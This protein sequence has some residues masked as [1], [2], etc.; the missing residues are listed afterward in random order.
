M[1]INKL[2]LENVFSYYGNVKFDFSNS[3]SLNVIIGENGFGKTSLINSIKIALHG[4]TK[5]VLRIGD[6]SLTKQ[7]YIMGSN[8][9]SG[10]INRVAKEQG[11]KESS[12]SIN[13][14][15]EKLNIHTIKRCFKIT[16]TSYSEYLTVTKE[17]TGT[18]LIDDEAQDYINS[19]IIN[20]SLAK[21]FL[22]DGER[23][24]DIANFS[25]EEFAK[26]LENVFEEIGIFEQLIE[27]MKLLK[28][29]YQTESI[30][31]KSLQNLFIEKNNLIDL[32]NKEIEN[33]IEN[34]KSKK[35][36]LREFK[37]TGTELKNKIEKLKSENKIEFQEVEKELGSLSISRDKKLDVFKAQVVT[38]LPL[39]L[40]KEL[41]LK[42]ESDIFANYYDLNYLP[43]EIIER[44]KIEFIQL[45]N[46][47]I[48]NGED[49]SNIMEIFDKVFFSENQEKRVS[50]V[51]TTKIKYQFESLN[52]QV[53]AFGILLDNIIEIDTLIKEQE[54]RLSTLKE[55]IKQNEKELDLLLENKEKNSNK[56][57]ILESEIENFDKNINDNRLLIKDTEKEIHQI[58]MR[59]HKEDVLNEK[60]ST[61]E[62][63]ILVCQESIDITK[64]K[65]REELEKNVNEKLN[66]LIKDS[67]D[68][69]HLK[70]YEDFT[71]NLFDK[72][73]KKMD[74]L[75]SSS[76]Q[77][78]I[79]AT[80]LIWAISE[81][82]NTNMPMIVDTPLGRLDD[83]NQKLLLDNFYPNVA[84]QVIML[85]TPSELKAE[86]FKNIINNATIFKLSSNGSI[87]TVERV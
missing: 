9:F 44:K 12:I 22:F 33:F 38:C 52:L 27:D 39:L 78:Q 55:A 10:I 29:T 66:L 18:V 34:I 19:K 26:M 16:N 3:K 58:S 80:A 8:G 54:D 65:K 68:A 42:V 1:R 13:F 79:I 62:K 69:A 72:N 40:D 50:F 81:Y 85:P 75:S 83:K 48:Q 4:I 64:I 67:Y 32:K 86:G 30:T 6:Y 14:E 71:I 84:K 36:D 31:D 15:D 28:R 11:I 87:A 57:A 21:F 56:I 45:I 82:A 70:V 43:K 7:E 35:I 77:K 2:N 51:D 73:D 41:K 20:P 59:T 23:V 74:I 49:I 25:S 37:K 61:C 47:K 63:T 5:E 46:E 53:L 24:Q 76:G 60:I 17:S